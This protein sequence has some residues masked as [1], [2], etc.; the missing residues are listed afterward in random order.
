MTA[1]NATE[2]LQL[3]LK[4]TIRTLLSLMNTSP[5]PA[6]SAGPSTR[7]NLP[8]T[9]VGQVITIKHLPY[10]YLSAT[11]LAY[12]PT[13]PGPAHQGLRTQLLQ[14]WQR[15]APTVVISAIGTAIRLQNGKGPDMETE[16]WNR[17]WPTYVPGRLGWQMSAVVRRPGGIKAIME[18]IFGE[19][20]VLQGGRG[21]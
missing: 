21:M 2:D 19:N 16:G 1:A 5:P 4:N 20:A 6:S 14:S 10:I 13:F 9:V 15:L 3:Q 12:A 8:P 11:L 18:N 7:P 17:T